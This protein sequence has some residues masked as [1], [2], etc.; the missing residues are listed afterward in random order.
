M[1]ETHD[2]PFG[3]IFTNF[4]KKIIKHFQF[5]NLGK[6]FK[7]IV[8]GETFSNLDQKG[9]IQ[10]SHLSVDLENTKFNIWDIR[11]DLNTLIQI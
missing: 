11:E 6:L 10:N 5:T 8:I 9:Y 2:M 3:Y 1:L 4:T 7:C